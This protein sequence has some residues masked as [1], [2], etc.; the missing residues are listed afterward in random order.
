MDLSWIEVG[1]RSF[2]IY[3]AFFIL[4]LE[5]AINV[6]QW[7]LRTRT[8]P[9]DVSRHDI[10]K[11]TVI[12]NILRSLFS[13]SRLL[14]LVEFELVPWLWLSTS[15]L[16]NEFMPVMS[17]GTA[18][19]Y[20]CLFFFVL[21]AFFY[22]LLHLLD[23]AQFFCFKGENPF[24]SLFKKWTP[25]QIIPDVAAGRSVYI[26]LYLTII[27][28]LIAKLFVAR[29]THVVLL[30]MTIYHVVFIILYPLLSQPKEASLTVLE[31]E[32][33]DVAITELATTAKL[34]LKNIYVSNAQLADE[35][36][37]SG[38]EICGW[39]RKNFI[40]VNKRILAEY[41]SEDILALL[42]RELGFWKKGFP[43]TSFIFAQALAMYMLA[44]LID[45]ISSKSTYSTFGF[46]SPAVGTPYPGSAALIIFAICLARPFALY[47]GLLVNFG[48][49]RFAFEADN[50]AASLGHSSSLTSILEKISLLR[51][52]EP[53]VAV[54]RFYS[55]FYN[56]GA[57]IS[58]RIVW[59]ERL[60]AAE[61][62]KEGVI[63][64]PVGKE[65]SEKS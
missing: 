23:F 6:R 30:T 12:Y 17:E 61:D 39:P 2:S 62:V 21:S 58:E 55:M 52:S 22:F 7:R 56:E 40:V 35:N 5:L 32:V 37:E 43:I 47:Y 59:L 54:D 44:I 64:L 14:I 63:R 10:V 60:R 31:D 26:V 25:K 13:Y 45:F 29:V 11:G 1:W 19:F 48:Q 28:T 42:A 16:E 36:L 8:S 41:T 51:T 4:L 34:P 27:V 53:P 65:I 15:Q 24:A 33:L 46:P 57:S 20:H 38:I 9:P 18:D 50:Y 49:R 3:A